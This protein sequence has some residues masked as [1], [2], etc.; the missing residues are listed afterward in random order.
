M[1]SSP[2]PQLDVPVTEGLFTVQLDFIDE[3]FASGTALYLEIRVRPGDSEGPYTT[4]TPRQLLTP[5]PF[6]LYSSRTPWSGIMGMPGGFR[7]GIDDNTTYTAGDGLQLM[8]TQFSGKGSPYDNVVIVAKSGGDFTSIQ[9]ALDSIID[10]SASHPYIV[11]VAPGVYSER[12]TMKE[13]VD[14]EGS[15]ELNTKIT[16]TTSLGGEIGTVAGASNAELRYLT[17]ENTGAPDTAVAISNDGA[18]P[19][20]TH[21]TAVASGGVFSSIG[22]QSTNSSPSLTSVSVIAS[23]GSHTRGMLNINSTTTIRDSVITT[24]GGA[25]QIGVW[26]QQASTTQVYSSEIVASTRPVHNWDST[27]VIAGSLLS[28]APILADVGMTCAGVYD[29]N[30]VFYANTCP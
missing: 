12:V 20:L 26:S 18:S 6:A 28:G 16:T 23:G 14:I 8:D 13:W 3:P 21:I 30:Y 29:E 22:V 2:V 27:T 24:S 15:G 7:D 10:A 5:T 9:A 25:D 19:R 1:V 11:R 17:V 4:L